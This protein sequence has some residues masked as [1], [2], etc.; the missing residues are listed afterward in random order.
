MTSS[1][2]IA[3]V[4]IVASAIVSIISAYISFQNNK[5]N[6]NA[7]RSEIA[8]E[9]RLD[10]FSEVTFKMGKFRLSLASFL[11]SHS[12]EK[13]GKDDFED[14]KNIFIKDL[15]ELHMTVER[16]QVYFP[17]HVSVAIDR[18]NDSLSEYSD[19]LIEERDLGSVETLFNIIG[20]EEQKVVE[21]MQ[22]FIGLK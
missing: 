15:A 12:N 6:I 11:A 13:F 17:K 20:D 14:L 1:D 21:L 5:A 4:A 18:F 10:A 19:K 9:K 2:I 22:E 16:V 3:I 8:L 7:R